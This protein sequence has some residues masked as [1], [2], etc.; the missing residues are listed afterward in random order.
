MAA[1]SGCATTERELL[2]SW[3]DQLEQNA[4][5]MPFAERQL[6]SVPAKRLEILRI[7][8]QAV[9]DVIGGDRQVLTRRQPSDAV[10][11]LLIRTRG[12][13]EPRA[14]APLRRVLRK[15]DDRAVG[16]RRAF[17][18]RELAADRR[19]LVAEHDVDARGAVD[20][21]HVDLGVRDV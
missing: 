13:N 14:L 4:E 1:V 21:A 10:L 18:I 8:P 2:N 12:A 16:N 5:R 20:A 17:R 7:V 11:A 9:L 15:D 3:R 6:L 19:R